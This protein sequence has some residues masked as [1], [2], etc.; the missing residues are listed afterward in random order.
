MRKIGVEPVDADGQPI[1]PRGSR[2]E[3]R[4]R[5]RGPRKD[6]PGR[7]GKGKHMVG[8]RGRPGNVRHQGRGKKR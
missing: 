7:D 4:D 8:P 1:E 2:P 6:G 3:R 5:D